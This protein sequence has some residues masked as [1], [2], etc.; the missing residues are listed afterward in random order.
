M[1][2]AKENPEVE[3]KVE[4]EIDRLAALQEV[5]R[6]LKTKREQ[7]ATLTGAIEDLAARI[8]QHKAELANLGVQKVALEARRADLD[9]RLDVEAT[10]IRDSRMRMNRV[11]NDREL[12]ALKREVDLAKEANSQL[13]E[14]MIAAMEQLEAVEVRVAEVKQSLTDLQAESEREIGGRRDEIATLRGEIEVLGG[15]RGR[16][17]EGLSQSLRAR[18][19][20][21]FERRRGTAVVEVRNGTCLGCHMNL[22]PQLVNELKK[23]RDVRTCPS[24]H[25]ILYWRPEA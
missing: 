7:I 5:D 17:A 12:L 15:E 11:R 25:R 9:V 6:R 8:E 24:C 13:E 16:I 10:R 23:F 20:Q 22:P 14:Q 19:E 2:T 18:Y 4:S 3:D 1:I 21:L